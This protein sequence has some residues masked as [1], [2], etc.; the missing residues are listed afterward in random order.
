MYG[1]QLLLVDSGEGG[2]QNNILA[3]TAELLTLPRNPFTTGTGI[4][5][6]NGSG[7]TFR[8]IGRQWGCQIQQGT[9]NAVNGLINVL[10]FMAIVKSCRLALPCVPRNLYKG[11]HQGIFMN[12]GTMNEKE[13][14]H[15][16]RKCLY[17][18]T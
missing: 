18:S 8:Q 12:H 4:C 11:E 2:K 17:V 14:Q 15:P 6:P 10:Y 7:E 16:E 13:K 1:K 5:R 3:A 9:C